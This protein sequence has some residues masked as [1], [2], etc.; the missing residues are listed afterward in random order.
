MNIKTKLSLIFGAVV[1]AIVSVIGITSFNSSSEMGTSDAKNSMQISANLAANEIKGK[2]DDF[3]KMAQVSGQDPILS[4]SKSDSRV[5]SR[6]D[7]LASTYSFTSGNIL[8][9]NGV[10]RKDKTDFSDRDYVKKALSGNANISDLTL[11]KY[12]QN[13]GFSVA[14]PVYDKN[15]AVNGV[16]YYRMDVDF[17]SNILDQIS[18]SDNSYTYLVDGNGLVI[19]HPDKSLIGKYNITDT[20]SG[21]GDISKAI[22]SNESGA[23]E[24]TKDSNDYLCGYSPIED[25]NGWT[26]VVAAPKNDF[27]GPTKA[28]MKTLMIVSIIALV[29]ALLIAGI[30]SGKIGSA[31]HRVSQELSYLSVGDLTHEIDPSKRKDEIGHLQNSTRELQQT[32]RKII[33]ETNTILGGMASYDLRQEDMHP[34]PGDFNQL[35]DSVNNIRKILQGLI[36]QVQSAASSV[37]IGSSELS[38]AADALAA[39]T[40]TQASSISQLVS[41]V[42]EVTERIVSDSE[43]EENVQKRLQEL[44]S[45]IVTGNNRMDDLNAVVAEVANMSS[46]IQ[47]IISTIESIAFQI[48]ILALNASVEAAHA[49]ESGR[50]FAVVADEIS[51]LASKTSESS[52]QTADL[53]NNCIKQIE[54]AMTCADATSKCLKDIV[55]NSVQISEAFKTISNDTKIQADKS[56]HIKSEISNISDVVQTNTATAEETAAATQELSEQA[57]SLSSLIAKFHV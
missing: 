6:I 46:D 15:N 57:K 24:Y 52:K 7:S 32:F 56:V 54:A 43:N 13:Y 20:K 37:G 51:D 10:S 8:D 47:N 21:L 48:N 28:A 2:L 41:S 22:L 30:F 40:V 17:M 16:V 44:D 1:L 5:T 4:N 55:D 27:M 42:E 18:I 31:V 53:I 34:Y 9:T 19:V 12:T 23:G 29:A 14:S 26:V 39:G 36:R 49:G 11:S 33:N 35:S 25:T 3:M 50:G 45:L 38:S